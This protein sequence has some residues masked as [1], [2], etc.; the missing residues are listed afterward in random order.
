MS[1]LFRSSTGGTVSPTDVHLMLL[2]DDTL[3]GA[4]KQWIRGRHYNAG[5]HL[6]SSGAGPPFDEMEDS[7]C[8][9]QKADL[10]QVVALL[11]AMKRGLF[12]FRLGRAGARPWLAKIRSYSW[13]T[14]SRRRTCR[15]SRSCHRI[16][17]R[18]RR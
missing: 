1:Q 12:L 16:H 8:A 17:H 9:K 6:G 18:R 14:T 15:Q 4:T 2:H 13:R 3:T 10:E 5:G 7:A 11:R